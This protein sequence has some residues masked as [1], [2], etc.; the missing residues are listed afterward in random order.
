MALDDNWAKPGQPVPRLVDQNLRKSGDLNG[1]TRTIILDLEA[2]IQWNYVLIQVSGTCSEFANLPPC[3]IPES[4]SSKPYNP[5]DSGIDCTDK[6]GEGVNF[7][8]NDLNRH[9]PSRGY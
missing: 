2:V 1:G 3:R 7:V 8:S 6:F 5:G 4:P 9:L